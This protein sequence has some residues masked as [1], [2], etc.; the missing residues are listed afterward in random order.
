MELIRGVGGERRNRCERKTGRK[1]ERK[2]DG[3]VKWGEMG[4]KEIDNG[5]QR[6]GR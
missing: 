5:K 6:V 3:R 1:E 4:K 2:A